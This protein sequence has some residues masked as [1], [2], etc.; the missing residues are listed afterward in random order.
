[1]SAPATNALLPVLPIKNTVL[2]PHLLMPLSVGRATSRAAVETALASEDKTLL[3]ICQRN[4]EAEEPGQSDLFTVGTRA[5]IKKMA[6]AENAVELI[7][8]GVDRVVLE[9]LEQTTPFLKGSV[10]QLPLPD[11]ESPQVE[12]LRRAVLELAARAFSL[13]QPQAP[14][15]LNQLLAQ[16]RDSLQLAFLLGS[17]LS[18]DLE[19]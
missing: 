18:L 17:M 14:V 9:R 1:M 7:V 5:V 11:D 12:A 8:Q 10:R 6:R 2:Y 13:A 19:K 16:T 4:T 3:V 15:D